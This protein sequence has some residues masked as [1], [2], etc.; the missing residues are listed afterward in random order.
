MHQRRITFQARAADQAAD[1]PIPCTIATTTPVMRMGVAEVLDCSPQG[2]DLS[3]APLPLIIAHDSSQ[4]AVG[5]VDGLQATGDKVTGL[6]RF[7]TSPEAQQIRADVLAGI[8]PALSVGYELTGE[9]TPVDGGVLFSWRPFEVSIV[10]IPADPN[11]G[12]FRSH[13][14]ALPM[15]APTTIETRAASEIAAICHRHGVPEL[16]AQLI[17]RGLDTAA[18]SREILDELARRDMA[19][20]GHRNVIA[21]RS[22]D[23]NAGSNAESRAAIVNTLVH[24]MGGRSEGPVIRSV[25]LVGLAARTLEMAGQRVGDGDSRDRIVIRAMHTTGDFKQL[26]GAAVGRVLGQ[27]FEETPSAIKALARS[28]NL[29][30]FRSRTSV[31]LGGAP[32]LEKVNEHGEFTYG[33]VD[34]VGNQ[35]ALATYGR[36]VALTRQAIVNDDLGGFADLLTKFAQAAARREADELAKIVTAPPNVDGAALFGVGKSSLLTGAGAA[37]QFDALAAAVKALRLQKDVSGGLVALEPG[38]LLVPA[39][40]ETK[41]R[42]LAADFAATTSGDV[43]PYRLNVHVEPR[44]DAVSASAWYLVAA[45]QSSLEYGYLDGAQGVQIDQREGFEVDGVEF[46][47]RLDFGCGRVAGLGWVKSDPA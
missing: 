1:A 40:L 37:L 25:D 31:R 35:W 41:A 39:A 20:G 6:A 44:L 3:R 23:Y 29:P 10:P 16:S 4:L 5:V 15:N 34:D 22:G 47:A 32:S 18:A 19:S 28:V 7:G 12:F 9:G 36:I 21:T 24:R 46:R 38:A 27:V 11:S 8:H 33:T 42:Q 45:N 30:D 14:G 43:Q 17:Q 13:P 26:L 2:V